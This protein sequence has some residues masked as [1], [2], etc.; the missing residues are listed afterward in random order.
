MSYPLITKE[1]EN[2]WLNRKIELCKHVSGNSLVFNLIGLKLLR[3]RKYTEAVK[4]F[5]DAIEG[6]SHDSDLYT[7]LGFAIYRIGNFD[8][9]IEIFE[10]ALRIDNNNNEALHYLGRSFFSS[11]RNSE[12]LN[13]FLPLDNSGNLYGIEVENKYYLGCAYINNFQYN[14]ALNCFND[15]INE[16]IRDDGIDKN[17]SICLECL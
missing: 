1:Y 7:N 5:A 17:K 16:A 9:A 13:C 2:N 12:A 4:F 15:L 3:E 11:G 6:S 8:S 14:N 10:M